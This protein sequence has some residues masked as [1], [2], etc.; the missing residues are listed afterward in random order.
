MVVDFSSFGGGYM[1]YRLL[2]DNDIDPRHAPS[3]FVEGLTHENVVL[4]VANGLV[5]VGTVPTGT[6]EEMAEKGR[7]RMEDFRVIHRV[8]DDFPFVHSTRFYPEWPMVALAHINHK[9]A[10]VMR[11]ALVA[12]KASSPA[13]RQAGVAIAGWRDS[14]SYATVQKLVQMIGQS[15]Q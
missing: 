2:L 8:D 9:Q 13:T 6:L 7:I 14:T 5:D 1:A 11:R 12:M 15:L 4:A 3:S 10:M